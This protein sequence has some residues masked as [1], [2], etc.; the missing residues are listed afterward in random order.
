[1][2]I[3]KTMQPVIGLLKKSKYFSSYYDVLGVDAG[4][5]TEE[6]KSK[7]YELAKKYHPDSS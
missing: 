1:M 5:T 6:I 7:Y 4:A 2:L 3:G